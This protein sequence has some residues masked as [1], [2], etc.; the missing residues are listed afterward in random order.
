[1]RQMTR[2]PERPHLSR[3]ALAALTLAAAAWTLAMPGTA[4]AQAWPGKQ[5]IKFV[6]GLAAGSI[7]DQTT[8]F[9]SETIREGTGQTVL[10]ENKPGADSNLA[11]EQVAHSPADGYTALVAGNN[12]HAANI[13][14]YKKLNFDPYK[15]F[16]PVGTFARV[17]YM[18]VVNPDRVPARNFKDFV[19]YAKANPGKLTYGSATVAGRVSVEQMKLLVGFDATNVN[20]KS[21]PQAMA[22]LLGGQLD[23]YMTDIA[24]G[25]TQVRAGKVV[26]LAITVKQRMPAAPD[27][28]T[29]AEF[30]YPDY[31]FFSWLAVWLPTGSP[32]EAVRTLNALINKAMESDAG[33]DYL[34]KRGLLGA[35]GT[36]A[37]LQALQTSATESWGKAVLAAGMQAQ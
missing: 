26:A 13:H 16:V 20:Y 10:V 32:P 1:M 11:A 29:V 14:L 33:R 22:D 23:F 15:D 6:V 35:A 7:T 8:R 25:L 19:A 37:D 5:P 34:A 3:R 24:T 12:T 18:L 27:I 36:P 4:G 30:G 9:F 17:P 2:H 28:P 31:D 21:S